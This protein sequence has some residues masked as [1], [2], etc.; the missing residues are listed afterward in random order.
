MRHGFWIALALAALAIGATVLGV[1]LLGGDD[2]AA[3]PPPP[4]EVF[5]D[6]L[7]IAP[8]APDVGLDAQT[9]TTPEA[10]AAVCAGRAAA[11]FVVLPE[12]EPVTTGCDEATVLVSGVLRARGVAISIPRGGGGRSCVSAA[13]ADRLAGSRADVALTR[14]R[15]RTTR[16]AAA[17]AEA[18]ARTDGLVPGA[19]VGVGRT[20][21]V[22]AG[23]RFDRSNGLRVLAIAERTGGRCVAP[24]G[25][26]PRGAGYPL[27]RGA[28]LVASADG[29]AVPAV[30][31]AEVAVRAALET[32]PPLRVT[33][34]R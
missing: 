22:R 27:A 11:A 6:R 13:G 1:V 8:G 30:A 25:R 21:A 19:V 32:P 12:G 24:P 5:S 26:P 28:A 9:T 34:L 23:R 31:R 3:P 20:A 16:A 29:A 10:L 4:A 7:L 33:V 15:A 2:E 17:D 18:G 14:E